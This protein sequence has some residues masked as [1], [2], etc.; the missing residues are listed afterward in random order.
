[1]PK[2]SLGPDRQRKLETNLDQD[3]DR[4]QGH[5]MV[6]TGLDQGRR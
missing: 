2:I 6:E 1:V 4:G 5:A 3:P